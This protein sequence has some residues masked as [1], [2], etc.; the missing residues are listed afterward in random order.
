MA[1]QKKDY[2]ITTFTEDWE[3]HTGEHV[4]EFIKKHLEE[5]TSKKFGVLDQRSETEG[6]IT[7]RFF[8]DDDSY[9]KW[10]SD[11]ATYADNVLAEQTFYSEKP[12]SQ[13]Y[14][15]VKFTKN[16]NTTMAKGSENGFT[17]SY[18]SYYDD[19]SDP[20]AEDGTLTVSVN[21][22]EIT[23]L[24]QTLKSTSDADGNSYSVDLTDYLTSETNSV[25]VKVAN[26]HGKV[27]TKKYT[28]KVLSLSVAFADNYDET[29]IRDGEW[30]LRVETKGIS[31]TVY[32]KVY[33]GDKS[34]TISKTI[35]ASS[36]EFVIDK[37]GKLSAGKHDI[38]VWAVN[39]ENKI[40]TEK[41][42]TTFIKKGSVSAIGIGKDAPL[43][44][45]QYSTIQIPYYLYLP[46]EDIGT[47]VTVNIKVL[48]NN[49]ENETQ[50][51]NQVCTLDDNH[52]SGSTTLKATIPLDLNEYSP[53]ISVVISVGEVV[54]TTHEVTIKSA[55]VTLEPVD[56]CKVYYAM[57]GRTNDDEGI[58]NL[59]SYY[60]G[61]R[62]SRL[63]RSDN[64]KLNNYSGF[65]DGSGLTIGA[66]KYVTLKD[67]QPF[68]KDFGAN[69][70]KEGRT[71]EFEFETGIC[72]D[73]NAVIIDCMDDTTGFRVYANRI[74]VKCS[75][76][77]VLTYFPETKRIKMSLSID[78][79]TTHTVNNLGGDNKTE[80]DVNLAYLC[81]NGV[82]VRMF[83]YANA[84][85]KQSTVKDIIIGSDSAQVIL[86]SIRG[87]EKSI[88]PYQALD[89]FA[90]DTPDV[91]DVYD[92][93]GIFEHY[94]K[95]NMAKRND[96]LNS[97][98]NIHN[99]EEIIS[100]EKV[101][102]ALPTTPIIIWNVDNL[103][104]NKN[105]ND[106]VINATTF[107]NPL[108]NKDTDGWAM[109]PFTVGEHSFN[110]D[111]TS[112][113]GYPLPYKNFAEKFETTDGNSVDIIVGLEE[114]TETHKKYS[115]TV[116][117]EE[118][119]KE[120]VHKVN[121]ASSE[122]IFNIHAMN[123][124]QQILLGCAKSNPNLYTKPQS[125][126]EALGQIVTYRKSLSGFPEIGFR[127]TSTSGTDAPVFLSIYNFINN[128]YS[129]SFL[130]FPA[131][132][133]KS[134]QIWEVDENVN[135][136]NKVAGD[137]SKDAEGNITKSI[138]TGTPLYYARVPKKSPTNTSSKLGALTVNKDGSCND[139]FDASN[140]ELAVIKRFHNWVVSTNV[141]LAERYKRENG[142]YATLA[143][144]VTY[145]GTTYTKDNPAYRKAK[146]KNEA[147]QYLK[148]DS[149][150][151]Y[152]IF[153][154]WI[155]GM[156]SM[157]KNMSIA[158]DSITWNE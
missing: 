93:D 48:Y 66:G 62:T 100:Y 22:V 118:G 139:D 128:K 143:Q 55:G 109:A 27:V 129:A 76:G 98:G 112:S 40:T 152:F 54:S 137:N 24:S 145:N 138:L 72:A 36:G 5:L 116:G 132:D 144:S 86:Y 39:A 84:I 79:T 6:Q 11:Q 38:E 94:G 44:A 142:D 7:W 33:D 56:E 115:I 156:D 140:E 131:K 153:C 19:I 23:A 1:T 53:K 122:G 148:V 121:F 107:T 126:Q 35:N 155:I 117:V 68:S 20:D 120:M 105:N 75:T 67:W 18:N 77:G 82:C 29:I 96:I 102:K 99:P 97:N 119:E 127:R 69:G 2:E 21:G 45:S 26:A 85:W 28:I 136:F 59:E 123:M 147:S 130:G 9:A 47:E 92:S 64:F 12:V 15:K 101:K 14:I 89:N 158:F 57:R 125:E 104:Y 90:Y 43:T 91:N 25:E 113:N 51:A 10:Q 108:W 83:D 87:Y 3:G 111:G 60:N 73:E 46:N 80:A 150:I 133:Y 134:G 13:Y 141:L 37:G 50:I 81:L 154:Q 135:M 17:F 95:V 110:A 31:A 4:Q 41:I 52:T 58:D 34:T 70:S 63:I 49:G 32:C 88:T 157:D 78:G 16:P 114:E 71:I 149:A 146:F 61:V 106:V 151:F 8:A 42:H 65:L 30:A 124:Y 74:E 103:P